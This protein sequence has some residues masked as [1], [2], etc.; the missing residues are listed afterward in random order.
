VSLYM[1]KLATQPNLR[2]IVTL[3]VH[4]DSKGHAEKV[5]VVKD[6]LGVPEISTHAALALQEAVFPAARAAPVFQYVFRPPN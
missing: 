5:E 4:V 2:G 1:T 3:K 6:S